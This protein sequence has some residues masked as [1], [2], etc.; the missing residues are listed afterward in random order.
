MECYHEAKDL[1][2]PLCQLCDGN[3]REPPDCVCP[4]CKDVDHSET[5][6]DGWM[7]CDS[8]EE[9]DTEDDDDEDT[10]MNSDKDLREFYINMINWTADNGLL[11]ELG[12]VRSSQLGELIIRLGNQDKVKTA[13]AFELLDETLGNNP[14]ALQS[15]NSKVASELMELDGKDDVGKVDEW[16]IVPTALIDELIAQF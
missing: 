8:R 11:E 1:N 9:S 10:P 4:K 12:I 3:E 14:S 15:L 5:E 6:E 7:S 13:H 16:V 2:K